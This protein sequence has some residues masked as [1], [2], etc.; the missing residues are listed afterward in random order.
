M[1]SWKRST[2]APEVSPFRSPNT[3]YS[4]NSTT[5]SNCNVLLET[6][7]SPNR[8]E[9]LLESYTVCG[10]EKREKFAMAKEDTCIVREEKQPALRVF[11]V[12]YVRYTQS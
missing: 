7:K 10:T 9:L 11:P 2:P 3:A 1:T 5:A 6:D 8:T 4:Q 12:G